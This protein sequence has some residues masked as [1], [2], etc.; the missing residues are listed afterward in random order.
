MPVGTLTKA[1]SLF[2]LHTSQGLSPSVESVDKEHACSFTWFPRINR[3][4]L[5]LTATVALI[6]NKKAVLVYLKNRVSLLA[7]LLLFLL[8][9][10]SLKCTHRPT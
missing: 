9:P 4:K 6:F 10:P 3:Q 8:H 1:T 2:A 7:Y 5:F